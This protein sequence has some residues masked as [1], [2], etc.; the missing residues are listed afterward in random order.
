MVCLVNKDFHDILPHKCHEAQTAT[1]LI[2]IV[3]KRDLVEE[4][5]GNK[6]SFL[7][8]FYWPVVAYELF[9]YI[10]RKNH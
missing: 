7:F 4:R 2:A 1:K 9:P 5:R 3:L 10:H 8:I 6:N